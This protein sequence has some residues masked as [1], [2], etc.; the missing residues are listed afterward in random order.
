MT[1]AGLLAMGLFVLQTPQLA[2]AQDANT[3]CTMASI[4][5]NFGFNFAGWNNVSGTYVPAASVGKL[6]YSG[7]GS[8]SGTITSVT[9]GVVGLPSGF[10]GS[11]TINA[12]CTGAALITPEGSTTTAHFNMV[13]S[14]QGSLIYFIQT[15]NGNTVSGTANRQGQG[16]H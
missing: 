11:Y 6:I 9:G 2:K 15:D 1:F 10:S 4:T 16:P 3:G 13:A 7:T 8:L 12:D 5:G 14:G